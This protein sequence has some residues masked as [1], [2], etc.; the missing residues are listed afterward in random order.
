MPGKILNVS[1]D[2][3]YHKANS[4]ACLGL[5]ISIASVPETARTSFK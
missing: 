2:Q 4:V 3:Y 1:N 5:Q